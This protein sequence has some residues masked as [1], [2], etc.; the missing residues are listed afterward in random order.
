MRRIA[1]FVLLCVFGAL[2]PSATMMAL[3]APQQLVPICCRAHGAH[4]CVMGSAASASTDAAPALRQPGCPFGQSLRAVT[5][6]SISAVLTLRIPLRPFV[7]SL[8]RQPLPMQSPPACCA[9]PLPA[10]LLLPSPFKSRQLRLGCTTTTEKEMLLSNC[11]LDAGMPQPRSF[12]IVRH[13]ERYTML[14]SSRSVT[15][16]R[17]LCASSDLPARIVIALAGWSRAAEL[18]EVQGVVHD[19]QHRPIGAGYVVQE[20]YSHLVQS[21]KTEPR[22]EFGFRGSL[23]RV[24]DDGF[25]AWFRITHPEHHAGLLTPRPCCTSSFGRDGPDRLSSPGRPQ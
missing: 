18:S 8:D 7:T 6:V 11:P 3:A 20:F 24:C 14:V 2:L 13:G 15:G 17:C 5:T 16:A 4:A 12:D 22:G 10:A 21:T 1:A 25:T 9:A 19:P 23:R